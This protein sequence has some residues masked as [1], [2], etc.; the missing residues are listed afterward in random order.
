MPRPPRATPTRYDAPDAPDAPGGAVSLAR[1]LNRAAS[2]TKQKLIG[3]VISRVVFP[4]LVRQLL[5]EHSRGIIAAL[6][7]PAPLHH[8][9]LVAAVR[10]AGITCWTPIAT[11]PTVGRGEGAASDG[12]TRARPPRPEGQRHGHRPA[13]AQSA[14]R[15]CVPHERAR[16]NA[17]AAALISPVVAGGAGLKGGLI[18]LYIAPFPPLIRC[19]RPAPQRHDIASAPFNGRALNPGSS[20]NPPPRTPRADREAGRRRASRRVANLPPAPP[21]RAPGATQVS[22]P[23][24]HPRT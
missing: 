21:R 24:A 2:H 22:A 1:L 3:N 18:F 17:A 12:R 4:L 16:R 13:A 15:L 8:E 20:A 6:T 23:A 7:A 14:R 5:L 11:S 9:S 19:H 10:D